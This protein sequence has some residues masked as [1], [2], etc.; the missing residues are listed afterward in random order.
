MEELEIINLKI[1]TLKTQVN[2]YGQ[3][4][5]LNNKFNSIDVHGKLYRS[6][7]YHLISEEKTMSIVNF[8]YKPTLHLMIALFLFITVM[9]TSSNMFASELY[10]GAA[11]ADISPA[12]PVA[13]QGQGHLR[14][15]K[16]AETPLA[17]SVI[18]LESREGNRSL[19]AA[20]MVSCDVTFL[21]RELIKMVFDEVHK[22]MPELNES[23]I[24]LNATHT[25]TAPVLENNWYQIPKTGVLQVE[26]YRT[27]FVQ[28]VTE[29]IIKA[30]NNRRPGSV[31][32]GLSHAVVGYNR[33]PVFSDGTAKMYENTNTPMFL[34]IEA[35]EDHDVNVLFFWDKSSKLI[36]TAVNVSCP[37]QEAE[38]RYTVNAD[39]WYPVREQLKKRFGKD[40]C[41]LGWTSAA[42]DI[43]TRRNYAKGAEERMIK[44]RK[45]TQ[46]EEMGRRVVQAVEE[47]YEA[48]KKERYT[49]IQFAHK[50]EKLAL[51][52]RLVTEEEYLYCKGEVDKASAQ[53]AA[54][55]K[56][57][58]K[59]LSVVKWNG[60]VLNRYEKQ[61]TNPH[62][63]L[64]TEIHVLRLGDVAICTNEFELYT[65]FGIRI[66]ARSNALQTFTIQLAGTGG[67]Y[68]ATE[69]A[70]NHGGYG[71]II[72][73]CT[74]TPEGGQI[75]VE[76]TLKLINDMFTVPVK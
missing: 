72:Q 22:K 2:N 64:E 71:A 75:L 61:K 74:V 4:K 44:L 15:A 19:D 62:P 6:I 23:K 26:E 70:T 39:Y 14:I 47:T 25:H 24:I 8:I 12:L 7:N 43:S 21:P 67:S 73:S 55:P 35:M 58:E 30:W 76:H 11:T 42:G 56:A 33:R 45:L 32:W 29:A 18:A 28:R 31:T 13:L 65:D 68:L 60:D 36:A 50:V 1:I 16:T 46:L 54:D 51:P 40:L 10:I 41:V 69:N 27:F 38:N 49:N 66:Q 5:S 37:A 48:V 53:I 3:T 34:N 52:M 59:V 20:I 17:A 57:A 63:D 9:C